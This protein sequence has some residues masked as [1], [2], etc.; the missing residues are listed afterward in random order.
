M[1]FQKHSILKFLINKKCHITT[2]NIYY[3]SLIT[4]FISLYY[5]NTNSNFNYRQSFREDTTTRIEKSL[6]Y[7]NEGAQRN[8]NAQNKESARQFNQLDGFRSS[9][10]FIVIQLAHVHVH[11]VPLFPIFHEARTVYPQKTANNKIELNIN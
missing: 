6:K 2:I 4:C 10:S 8:A 9:F 11:A 5:I 7:E 1:Q 3:E